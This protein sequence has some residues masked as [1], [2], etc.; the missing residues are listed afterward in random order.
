MRELRDRVA[1][2]TGAGSGIGAALAHAC[3]AAGMSVLVA[4]IEVDAAHEVAN[5]LCFA[6]ATAHA[7]YVDVAN[8]ASVLALA[9]RAWQLYGGCHLL[10]NNAGVSVFKQLSQTS[11]A[12]WQ[13]VLSVNLFG[14][15]NGIAAFVP[16]L[17]EQAQ[18]AHIVNVA[19]M[20]GL[21]PLPGFGAYAAS[22]HAVVGLSEVLQLELAPH[23]IGVSIV[24]PGMVETRIQ[25]S[26][27]NRPGAAPHSTALPST[28][29]PSIAKQS[30]NV[31]ENASAPDAPAF[32]EE[33]GQI[34]APAEVA[35]RILTAV[36]NNALYV[37]THA[38]WGTLFAQRSKKI[39]DAFSALL[40]A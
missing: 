8:P 6:G 34:I 36:Q 21:I 15:A 32:P 37:P 18:P 38:A 9:E 35:A 2:I 7:T 3:A 31:S 13:W 27:R 40:D 24:C 39:L 26:E 16:R 17:I 23:A 11:S 1:V 33:L 25:H 30:T 20:A 22:K 19:S 29:P 10:C 14:V 12:D 28:A 4:D 5:A